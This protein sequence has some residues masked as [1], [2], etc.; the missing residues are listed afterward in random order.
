VTLKTRKG[1]DVSVIFEVSDNGK[2][3]PPAWKGKLFENSFSTKGDKGTGLGLLVSRKIVMEH[4][5]EITFDSQDAV[6][7]TF[8]VKFPLKHRGKA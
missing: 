4:N 5:G 3:I 1:D 6:G 8:K 2:G 7:T